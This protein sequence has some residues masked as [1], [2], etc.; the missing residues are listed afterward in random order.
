M[1][2]IAWYCRYNIVIVPRY[3]MNFV[4]NNSKHEINDSFKLLFNQKEAHMVKMDIKPD[5]IS[6]VVD[7]SPR[8]SVFELVSLIK[9]RSSKVLLKKIAGDINSNKSFWCKGFY[10]ETIE[11]DETKIKEYV[12]NRQ[13]QNYERENLI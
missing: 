6:L 1:C 9:E 7:I 4:L 13:M 12:S 3:K 5:Y 8:L 2:G 11:N 10:V